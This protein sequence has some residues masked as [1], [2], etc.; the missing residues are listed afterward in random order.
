LSGAYLVPVL[1]TNQNNFTVA[2]SLCMSFWLPFPPS[3]WG[4]KKFADI[5]VG[6]DTR[7][8]L[9]SYQKLIDALEPK[10]KFYWMI[11]RIFFSGLYGT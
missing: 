1:I 8:N 7:G 5:L 4:E 3:P 11:P 10:A 9:A 6:S 2:V